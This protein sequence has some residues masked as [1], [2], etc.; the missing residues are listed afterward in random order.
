MGVNIP[1]RMWI[2]QIS[3][4]EG[5]I[6]STP[7]YRLIDI[8]ERHMGRRSTAHLRK[9]SKELIITVNNTNKNYKRIEEIKQ[10]KYTRVGSRHHG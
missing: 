10:G 4:E 1:V 8:L 2:R 6:R 9:S 3:G 7:S 5:A